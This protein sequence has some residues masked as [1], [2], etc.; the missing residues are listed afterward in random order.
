MTPGADQESKRENIDKRRLLL[1]LMATPPFVALFLFLPAG[2]WLW[3]RGWLFVA[4]FYAGV[5]ASSFYLRR[6]NPDV[7]AARIN[8]HQGTEPWDKPLLGFLFVTWLTL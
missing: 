2:D 5:T 3:I 6:V 8:P 4:V 1:Y 7:L